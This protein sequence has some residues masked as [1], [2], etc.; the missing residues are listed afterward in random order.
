MK[1]F[2]IK[3]SNFVKGACLALAGVVGLTV[4]VSAPAQALPVTMADVFLAADVS[5]LNSNVGTLLI[6]FIGI[7][8]LFVA[9][10]YLSK[11]GVR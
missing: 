4:A 5:T 7:S 3:A 1:K 8:L 6:A 2:W 9:R 11:A 10:R